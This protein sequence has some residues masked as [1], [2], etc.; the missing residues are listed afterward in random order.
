VKQ[1]GRTFLAVTAYG[2]S[3]V[4]AYLGALA[5]DLML[6]FWLI[7]PSAT[8]IA[9]A[10]AYFRR[11]LSLYEKVR[12]Y[13]P[14]LKVVEQ[15]SQTKEDLEKQLAIANQEVAARYQDGLQEGWAQIVGPLRAAFSNA[16]LQIKSVSVRDGRIYLAASRVDGDVPPRGSR[17]LVQVSATGEPKGIAVVESWDK[18]RGIVWLRSLPTAE[19]SAFWERMAAHAGD[20]S[21]PSGLSLDVPKIPD[22]DIIFGLDAGR[23]K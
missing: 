5:V 2:T 11:V 9:F 18:G 17:F 14:L 16:Q 21:A 22:D 8:L 3:V 1:F 20:G 13:D 6:A 4:G 23:V 19:A 15:L 7:I 12:K 10:S